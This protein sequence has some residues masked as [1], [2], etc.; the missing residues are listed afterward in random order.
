MHSAVEAKADLHCRNLEAQG[1]S[2]MPLFTGVIKW[3]PCWGDQTMQTLI[4]RDYPPLSKGLVWVGCFMRILG[5]SP[6]K[7]AN[8][9]QEISF[10]ISKAYLVGEVG[11]SGAT[12]R[13][14][15]IFVWNWGSGRGPWKRCLVV[16]AILTTF[17]WLFSHQ[18]VF[19][20]PVIQ[21]VNV[22]WYFVGCVSS[23]L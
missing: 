18:L 17:C 8:S 20:W 1:Y 4:F 14:P 19:Y 7:N 11:M 22:H 2:E 10:V 12:L 3:H 6:P 15:C 9:P 5:M 23:S 13:F 16:V 21:V